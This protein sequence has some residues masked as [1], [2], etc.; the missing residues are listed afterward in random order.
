MGGRPRRLLAGTVT[1]AAVLAG[2]VGLAP[3]AHAATGPDVAVTSVRQFEPVGRNPTVDELAS[4]AIE[5]TNLGDATARSVRVDVVTGPGAPGASSASSSDPRCSTTTKGTGANQVSTLSCPLN[6]LPPGAVAHLSLL[7]R[8]DTPGTYTRTVTV[9]LAGVVR[10]HDATNDSATLTETWLPGDGTHPP[11]PP[12][13]SRWE[14]L[15]QS[16]QIGF[17]QFL[18]LLTGC[19]GAC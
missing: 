16:W 2:T 11:L 8:A 9:R 17:Q 6:D 3:P 10:D 14:A 5:V 4:D 13:P 18:N 1:T 7:V 12:P 19:H 15:L